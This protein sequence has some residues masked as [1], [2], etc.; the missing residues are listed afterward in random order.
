MSPHKPKSTRALL[1]AIAAFDS[2]MPAV[3]TAGTVFGMS[4]T[5]VIPP[6]AAAA[7]RLAKSSFSGNPGSRLWTWTS[8][9][10]GSTYIPDTSITLPCTGRLRSTRV[11]TPSVTCTSACWGPTAVW[12][13]PPLNR[14]SVKLQV[15]H[16]KQR[17]VRNLRVADVVLA[18]FSAVQHDDQMDDLEART[19]KHLHRAKR[20]TA[21][22]DDVLDH[23]HPLPCL[24]ATF[25][26][27]R[28][29]VSLW[30]FA[31]EH[32]RKPSVHRYGSAEQ[33]SAQLGRSQSLRLLW[34]QLRELPR[35]SHQ[36]PGLGLEKE[37]VEVVIRVFARPQ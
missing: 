9:P 6:A 31:H 14:S 33:H 12:T 27:L 7:V 5:T 25:E 10:P 29:S 28:G 1:C 15:L 19:A 21:R 13:V 23:S 32:E 17:R 3:S 24:E 22:G 36:K 2:S 18:T 35:D 30:L 34:H 8:T 37:L 26:L 4:S 11:I 16:A 20:V